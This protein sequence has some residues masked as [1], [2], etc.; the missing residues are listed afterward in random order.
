MR[1]LSLVVACVGLCGM[2]TGQEPAPIPA[3]LKIQYAT[4]LKVPS[5]LKLRAAK[6]WAKN[7]E[8]L[9]KA[10]LNDDLPKE[11]D[12]RTVGWTRGVRNQGNC[13][14]CW[15]FA[16]TSCISNSFLRDGKKGSSFSE[17]YTLDCYRNG[18]CDGDWPETVLAH[19]KTVGLPL[20]KDYPAYAARPSTCRSGGM[21]L[22]K[23]KDY[24]YV[25]PED[26]VPNPDLIKAAIRQHGPVCC[27]VAVTNAW[28]AYRGE[29]YNGSGGTG[30]NHAVMLVGWTSDGY[31][32]MENSWGTSWG[33]DGYMLIKFGADRI[34]YGAMWADSGFNS[35][36]PPDPDDNDPKPVPGKG[37]TGSVTYTYKDGVLTGVTTSNKPQEGLE[38]DLKAA[39]VD[40]A[41]IAALVKLVADLRAKA[42]P[43][44][45][46][47]DVLALLNAISSKTSDDAAP[48]P[49]L[50][51]SLPFGTLPGVM[52]ASKP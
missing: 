43:A 20:D 2:A 32:I 49:P 45:I 18:G 29:K 10:S 41:V 25:G 35:P 26:G 15:D 16:A 4:G 27:A 11:F 50:N 9:T 3:E 31:W 19:A 5:D 48:A 17:Q 24:G 22:Y 12:A 38:A 46:L 39:G 42:G 30:I 7:G 13:G 33:K 14:S 34:G 8:R 36:N 51:Q 40:P 1:W 21:T 52:P 44:V 6:S 28:N 47:A 23:I 37:F